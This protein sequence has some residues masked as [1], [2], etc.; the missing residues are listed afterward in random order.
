MSRTA[1]RAV[2][3]CLA[4]L[5]SAATFAKVEVQPV[6]NTKAGRILAVQ[7]S[8]DIA[9]GDYEALMKGLRANP[10]KFDR[11]LALLDSIGG[12]VTEAIRMGRLLRETGFDVMVPTD[13]VCQ[14]TCVYLLAAGRTRTVRGYVG[15]H[16]PYFPHGDSAL[17]APT[18]V[19][20]SPTAYLR[21]M[22]V[23]LS[24]LDE[25]NSIEPTR[26]RVLTKDELAKYRL[27]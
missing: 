8:E 7:V 14:G 16:R 5:C 12:S 17:A 10:G 22:N 15:L 2:V 4:T 3:F 25:M 27:N 9:P 6:Q 24:L 19:G 21:D 18:G 26:M 23:P 13:G 11:K 1:I 20:Y